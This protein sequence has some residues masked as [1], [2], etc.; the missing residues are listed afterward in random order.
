MTGPAV[1]VLR[2]ICAACICALVNAMGGS[3]A[4]SGLR[5]I[6]AG[7]VLILAA[8]HPGGD[9]ELPVL[10]MDQIRREADIAVRDGIQQ[11]KREEAAVI[12]DSCAAYIWN[13]ADG[14][15]AT[16]TVQVE[17][18]ESLLPCAVTVIGNLTE[19]TR[20]ELSRMLTSEFGLG[21]E[22]QKWITTY[23]SSGSQP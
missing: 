10:D 4:G 13:K 21:E 1:Y 20:Q 18:D 11:A 22:A 19:Q 8:L 15:G 12:S 2:L 14:L 3:G 7:S 5:R 6:I 23:Q 17:L 16:V 9:F